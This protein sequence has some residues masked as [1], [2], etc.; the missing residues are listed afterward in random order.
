MIHGTV[1]LRCHLIQLRRPS[2]REIEFGFAE[3]GVPRQMPST[4]EDITK[5]LRS[6]QF[7][8]ITNERPPPEELQRA[9]EVDGLM[10]GRVG[11]P[12]VEDWEP[13]PLP[14]MGSAGPD[15]KKDAPEP[16]KRFRY[17]G[18]LPKSSR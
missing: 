16:A 6:G 3:G 14:A 7:D 17:A 1:L 18:K 10:R 9:A 12:A 11:Q 4:M 15:V 8:D 5:L 13:G 2:A